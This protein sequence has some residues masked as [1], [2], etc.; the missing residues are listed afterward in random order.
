MDNNKRREQEL[1]VRRARAEKA[2][3]DAIAPVPDVGATD[4]P[5]AYK[6]NDPFADPPVMVIRPLP[7]HRRA[8]AVNMVE[9]AAAIAGA[10]RPSR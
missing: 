5:V 2:Q 3:Q 8:N 10:Y 4:D 1:L 6:Q 9:L 7:S